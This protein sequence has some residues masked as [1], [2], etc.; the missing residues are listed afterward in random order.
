MWGASEYRSATSDINASILA[1]RLRALFAFM[2]TPLSQNTTPHACVRQ[3][4]RKHRGHNSRTGVGRGR[5]GL[6]R[7][8]GEVRTRDSPP[9]GRDRATPP[10]LRKSSELTSGKGCFPTRAACRDTADARTV[11]AV[12]GSLRRAKS[13]RALDGSGPL[14]R[15]N[16]CDGRLRR[17]NNHRG[18]APQR[19]FASDPPA[20]PRLNRDCTR[21]GFLL[22]CPTGCTRPAGILKLNLRGRPRAV[23]AN[24]CLVPLTRGPNS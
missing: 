3:R 6:A 13:R 18:C 22:M 15:R 14:W 9:R 16:S 24:G 20:V 4:L 2:T 8:T 1:S 23:P 21:E 5:S 12:K 10:P 19:R 17:E 11:L 7:K